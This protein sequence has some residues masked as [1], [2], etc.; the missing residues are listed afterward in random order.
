MWLAG[1]GLAL[2]NFVVILDMSI[3]NVS[4]PHIAG[5]LAVSPSQ[6]TWTITSY[7]VAEAIT[8][9]LA[10]WLAGRFGALRTLSWAVLGFGL[11]SL[12]CG[13]ARTIE[14][15]VVFRIFQGLCGGPIMPMT[16][17]MLVRVFPPDKMNVANALW[18][19]T[20]VTAPVIGPVAGGVIADNISW[21]WIFYINLPVVGLSYAI[22]TTLLRRFETPIRRE[23]VD[24]IGMVLL[25]LFVGSLQLVLDLGR[26]NDWFASDMIVSLAVVAAIAFA[27][28]TI[29]EL[30]DNH[31]AVDLRV[32][33]HR[34]L[35]LGLPV[36]AAGYGSLIAMLVIAPLWL[37]S[38][39]G[40]TASTAGQIL[41]FQGILAMVA[42][43]IAANLIQRRDMRIVIT[44]G[45]MITVATALLRMGWTTDAGYWTFAG[46]Q[47][48]QGAAL[49]MFFIG[50]MTMAMSDVP[51]AE[52]AMA[53][54]LLSFMRTISS[55]AGA[56][57]S[58]TA[59]ES[60]TRE[61]R[62]QLVG[63]MHGVDQLGAQLPLGQD[64]AGLALAERLVDAQAATIGSISVYGW[65]LIATAASLVLV[66]S[67]RRTVAGKG[68]APAH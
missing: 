56:A 41:A 68:P 40:Y 8:V 18:A 58:T 67:N 23:R 22:V 16:Q 45:M 33:R 19:M 52:F 5:G 3:T 34:S 25:V 12:L 29:W 2:T 61:S 48:L 62:A 39:I 38:V 36:M 26:E 9:P 10:G 13:V 31:P 50:T 47:F 64:R 65:A 63:T 11:F 42:A 4:I 7:A 51:Q 55:A 49:P 27:A 66:W 53:A 59:W 1:I 15:L 57:L 6:G 43:P 46:A 28:F 21:P 35:A 44:I 37:Q 32:L 54:G 60:A 20:A 17:T 24:G 14:L 30:T